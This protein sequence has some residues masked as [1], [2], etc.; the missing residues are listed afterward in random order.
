[1]PGSRP[2]PA[3]ARAVRSNNTWIRFTNMFQRKPMRN[4][5][6]TISGLLALGLGVAPAAD[7]VTISVSP[8]QGTIQAGGSTVLDVVASGLSDNPSGGAIGGY[9]LTLT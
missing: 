1:M 4:V 5:T 6:L 7:A 8:E 9:D 3:P 2:L